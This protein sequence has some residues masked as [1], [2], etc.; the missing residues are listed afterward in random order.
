MAAHVDAATGKLTGV[1]SLARFQTDP[2]RP[3]NL[4][5]DEAVELGIGTELEKNAF[6]RG[7]AIREYLPRDVYVGCNLSGATF[8][9][10]EF[11]E[12]FRQQDLNQIVLEITEHD[13]IKDY[14]ELAA[15]LSEFR[16]QGL[17]LAIDDFGAGYAGFRHIVELNPDIIKLDMSLVRNIDRAPTIQSVVRALVGFAEEHGSNLLAEGV[18]TQAELSML[19]SLGIRR[20]QGYFFHKPLQRAPLLELFR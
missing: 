10:P 9:E 4:W 16:S 8:L 11:Q 5:F 19:Q 20:A 1:E 17:R 6:A 12:F 15:S 14:S 2:Y 3:P 7:M 13:A 18:E